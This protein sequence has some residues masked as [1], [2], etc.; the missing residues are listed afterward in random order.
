MFQAAASTSVPA[1]RFSQK[2]LHPPSTHQN[3]SGSLFHTKGYL[4]IYNHLAK[5]NYSL[6]LA[7]AT[8]A[9]RSTRSCR[10]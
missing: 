10:V 9:G 1:H 6:A 8:V 3:F 4:K 5:L 2:S 7:T